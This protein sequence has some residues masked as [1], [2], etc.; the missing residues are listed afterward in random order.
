MNT[1]ATRWQTIV[2]L[3]LLPVLLPVLASSIP[4]RGPPFPIAQVHPNNEIS[5]AV[6]YDEGRDRFLVVYQN[7]TALTARCMTADGQNVATYVVGSI[8]YSVNPDVAY[9]VIDDQYLVVFETDG[10][11]EGTYVSGACCLQVGCAG[12]PFAISGDRPI[13]GTQGIPAVAYNQHGN[14]HDYL[15]VWQDEIASPYHSSIYARRLDSLGSGGPSFAVRDDPTAVDMFFEPDV[16][17]NLNHNDW[18]VVYTAVL[19]G[20]STGVDIYGR[21][22]RGVDSALEAEAPI[23]AWEGNQ[24]EPAVAAY[25]LNSTTPYLVAYTDYWGSAD[26]AVRGILLKVDGSLPDPAIYIN[27]RAVL[28]LPVRQPALA[29]SERLGGYTAV[30]MEEH[31][32]HWDIYGRRINADGTLRGMENISMGQNAEN[33]AVAGGFPTAMVVWQTDGAGDWD[34][35]GRFLGARVYLPLV[36]RNA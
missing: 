28:G 21:R 34:V 17:Y 30:W 35:Y 29:S 8:P 12:A 19:S 25:R 23:D 5:P 3:F 9:N 32:G 26:G 24:I 1:H 2:A 22:V 20:S 4:F 16:A 13:T 15:V 6:A 10:M 31:D 36:L 14:H 11:I 18:L 33:P 7:A 27:I